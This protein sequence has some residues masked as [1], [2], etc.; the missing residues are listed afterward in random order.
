MSKIG[1]AFLA[2]GAH[3]VSAGASIIGVSGHVQHIAPPPDARLNALTSAEFVRVWDERQGVVLEHALRVDATASGLYNAAGDL[4]PSLLSAGTTISSHYIHF[5]SP[6]S[7]HASANGVVT[8]DADILGVICVGDT[9]AAH[10]LD[11]SDYLSA[12]TI[13]S[14]GIGNRGMELSGKEFFE[15]SADHRSISFSF[16]ISNPGDYV[17][18]ITAVPTPG[19]CALAATGMTL[20]GRRRRN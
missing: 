10:D 5:D 6:G 4:V 17:R 1:I 3:A 20:I 2:V 9:H 13:Y 15:I 8:F 12:G 7:D 18:V 19:T 16:H 11:D 14:T